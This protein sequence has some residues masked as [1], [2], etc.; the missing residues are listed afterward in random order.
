MTRSSGL[1][2]SRAQGYTA[3]ELLVTIAVLA[4][5]TAYA[6]P[7]LG[8]IVV[9]NRL[10]VQAN[11]LVGALN[12]ARSEAVSRGGTVALCP[13]RPPYTA[14][15]ISSSWSEGWVVFADGGVTGAIDDAADVLR[16]FDALQSGSTLDAS[17]TQAV[18]YLPDGFLDASAPSTFTLRPGQCAGHDL[19]IIRITP[20]GRP[21]VRT[22][23]C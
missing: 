14:C 16:V 20:Q 17:G 5:I 23:S 18:R 1:N 9:R 4:I 19:R 3:I 2:D 22:A 13:S 7:A 21:Q 10:A 15:D 8:E 11:E 6:I 12:Y